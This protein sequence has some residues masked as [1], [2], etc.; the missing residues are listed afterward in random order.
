[1]KKGM[2]KPTKK[3]AKRDAQRTAADAINRMPRDVR[4]AVSEAILDGADWRKVAKICAGHGFAGVTPQNVTNYRKGGHKEYLLRQD[5]IEA[6]RRDSE[7]TA[8][9]VDHYVK[10]GGS[11]AEA[12]LL[13]SAEMMSQ[14]L[15]GMG[16]E[17]LKILM[18]TDPKALFGVTRELARIAELLAKK[19]KE[20]GEAPP[21]VA[22]PETMSDEERDKRIVDAVDRALGIKK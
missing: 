13:A 22:P 1:M 19:T 15:A 3:A 7:T 16:P 2:P 10:N 18:A 11:P 6:I 12:G 9:L 8:A 20:A 4:A 14:A 21:P 5:R 17:A